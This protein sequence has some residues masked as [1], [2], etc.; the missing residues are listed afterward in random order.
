M[1]RV[2]RSRERERER[3]SA[4]LR[5]IYIILLSEYCALLLSEFEI[6]NRWLCDP[7][8]KNKTTFIITS[9]VDDGEQ[10]DNTKKGNCK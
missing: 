6:A 5:P 2:E 8:H 7:A 10:E 3:A 9:L 1:P 4:S